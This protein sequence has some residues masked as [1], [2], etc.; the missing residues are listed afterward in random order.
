[1]LHRLRLACDANMEALSDIVEVDETYIGG[2]ERNKHNSKKLKAGRGGK[3]QAKVIDKTDGKTLKKF[4]KNNVKDGSA[5]YT[6]EHKDYNNLGTTYQ[7]ET[8]KHN[9]KEYMNAWRI[10]TGLRVSGQC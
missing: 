6:D 3:V 2:K 1:M 10:P 5:V 8:V 7:H 4:I 9:A